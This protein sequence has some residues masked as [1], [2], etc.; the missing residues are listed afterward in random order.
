MV[1]R[2]FPNRRACLYPAREIPRH[3]VHGVTASSPM[4]RLEDRYPQADQEEI[5][6]KIVS[7]AFLEKPREREADADI[8]ASPQPRSPMSI[9][10]PTDF[11]ISKPNSPSI[12]GSPVRRSREMPCT[13]RRPRHQQQTIDSAIES[14]SG[15]NSQKKSSAVIKCSKV[16]DVPRPGQREMPRQ[17]TSVASLRKSFEKAPLTHSSIAGEEKRQGKPNRLSETTVKLPILPVSN[18]SIIPQVPSHRREE[19][20]TI[21]NQRSSLPSSH[22]NTIDSLPFISFPPHDHRELTKLKA[23][24]AARLDRILNESTAGTGRPSPADTTEASVETPMRATLKSPPRSSTLKTGTLSKK[25]SRVADLRKLFD[26]RTSSPSPSRTLGWSRHSNS[27]VKTPITVTVEAV[28]SQPSQE[29]P[30]P[31]LTTEINID[32][33]SCDFG[34]SAEVNSAQARSM[35]RSTKS[36]K[37]PPKHDSPLKDRIK[38]FEKLDH[39]IPTTIDSSYDR[40]GAP[41]TEHQDAGTGARQSR[42]AQIW[43]RISNSVMQPGDAGPSREQELEKALPRTR[44]ENDI[45]NRHGSRNRR[46]RRQYSRMFGYYFYRSSERI[47]SGSTSSTAS[48]GSSGMDADNEGAHDRGSL[49]HTLSP[50]AALFSVRRS[51]PVIARISSSLGLGMADLGLDGAQ[52]SRPQRHE[53][54]EERLPQLRPRRDSGALE[55]IKSRQSSAKEKRRRERHEKRR[56]CR[57][58]AEDKGTI[59]GGSSQRLSRFP[60]G[61]SSQRVS[62]LPSAMMPWQAKDKGKGRAIEGGPRYN[63]QTDNTAAG[64]D[65]PR[66]SNEITETSTATP[67][68]SRDVKKTTA[69]TY[70]PIQRKVSKIGRREPTPGPSTSMVTDTTTTTSSAMADQPEQGQMNNSGGEGSSSTKKQKGAKWKRKVLKDKPWEKKTESGFVICHSNVSKI[71]EPKPRRPGQVKKL[72]SQYRDKASTGGR[73]ILGKLEGDVGKGVPARGASC[74]RASC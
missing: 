19:P 29:N 13:P 50:E 55:R 5:P 28:T 51:L 58:K 12:R 2:M 25:V 24:T 67:R 40:A 71:R 46:P 36:L 70:C 6:P 39:H 9:L 18:P 41:D 44:T 37:P 21:R 66:A 62:R 48:G 53:P 47:P 1:Q 27:R 35:A 52:Q 61:G 38:H 45:P 72:V 64:F 63:K 10:D 56:H 69:A 57:S 11:Q 74:T 17:S 7:V 23:P 43:R 4:S 16:A 15:T 14:R 59:A 20:G 30:A 31:E 32:D 8:A 3:H 73:L 68:A 42:A 60:S 26:T 34:T 22:P 33:F 54:F 49:E 65:T